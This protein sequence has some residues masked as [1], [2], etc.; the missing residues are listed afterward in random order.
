MAFIEIELKTDAVS[1]YWLEQ[2]AES[3]RRNDCVIVN[4]QIFWDLPPEKTWPFEGFAGARFVYEKDGQIHESHNMWNGS[5]IPDWLRPF[6]PD[7]A[8]WVK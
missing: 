8:R 1:K 6:M 7:N 4:G 2:Y 3:Q 5:Q